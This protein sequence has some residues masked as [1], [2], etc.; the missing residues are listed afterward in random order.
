MCVSGSSIDF[1]FILGFQPFD[2]NRPTGSSVYICPSL[3]LM[4]F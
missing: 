1:L 3:D 4:S 2:H